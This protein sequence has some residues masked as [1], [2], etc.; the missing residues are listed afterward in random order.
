MIPTGQVGVTGPGKLKCRY[1]IHAVG[2]R[3]DDRESRAFNVNLLANA[4]QNTL[5]KANE[6]GCETVSMPAI[7][8]GIF[9]FPKPLCAEVFFRVLRRFVHHHLHQ[10]PQNSPESN[11]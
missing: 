6:L 8:S 2:P 3:W 7:S 10:Q 5:L 9:G 1:V 4:I 11:G